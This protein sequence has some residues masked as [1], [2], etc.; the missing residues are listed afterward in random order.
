MTEEIAVRESAAFRVGLR[1]P[2]YR[3][4]NQ[5]SVYRHLIRNGW[6]LRIDREVMRVAMQLAEGDPGR[7]VLHRDGSVVV[8][9]SREQACRFRRH[10]Q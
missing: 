10:L 4:R 6:G 1:V 2:D 7:L 3:P 8:A 9:N 5:R